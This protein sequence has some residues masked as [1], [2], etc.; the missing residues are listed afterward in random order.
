MA[1]IRQ[2]KKYLDDVLGENLSTSVSRD[3]N[4]TVTIILSDWGN[5]NFRFT[6]HLITNLYERFN[7][8]LHEFYSPE[9]R[10]VVGIFKEDK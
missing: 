5:T 8:V 6:K 10:V 4:K 9:E 7:L 3:G 2:I 1:G